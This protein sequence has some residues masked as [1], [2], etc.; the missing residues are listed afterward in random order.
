MVCILVIL[1][2]GMHE[3]LKLLDRELTMAGLL[4]KGLRNARD[5]SGE[6][7]GKLMDGIDLLVE[8]LQ[9]QIVILIEIGAQQQ[10]DGSW[11]LM[12]LEK[13]RILTEFTSAKVVVSMLSCS[14]MLS[15]AIL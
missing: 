10:L 1:N 15:T 6:R 8:T 7:I 11:R 12:D 2:S 13:V 5:G 3:V 4:G 14:L 9:L